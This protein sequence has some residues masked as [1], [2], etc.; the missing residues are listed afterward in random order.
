MFSMKRMERTFVDA[1]RRDYSDYFELIRKS[2]R[3]TN[4]KFDMEI[5]GRHF[6]IGENTGFSR[7]FSRFSCTC[8]DADR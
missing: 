8:F 4:S 1:N 6:V 2:K 5:V 3:K 7:I